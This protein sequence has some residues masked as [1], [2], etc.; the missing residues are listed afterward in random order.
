MPDLIFSKETDCRY[1]YKCLRNCPVKAVSFKSGKSTVVVEECIF[2]GTCLEVCPQSAR[3]YRK[4]TEK[5]LNLQRPFLVSIAPSFFAYFENP[6]KVI[7]SLKKMG[8][9]VVQ[10]TA[11]G[12]EIVSRRYTEV[13]EKND[14]PVVTTACP[15]V[16]NLAEKHFPH[17]LKYLTPIDSPLMAHAKFLKKRYGDFPVVFVGPCIAKKEESSLVDIALTFEELEEIIDDMK[18]EEVF[19]DP[20]YPNRARFFP[21]TDGINY[22][23]S[24]PWEKKMVV[25]GVENLMRVFSR[26]DEYRNVFIEA[27]ACYGSCLN[28]PVM[29]KKAAGKDRIPEWQKRLPKEP[30]VDSFEIETFRSFRNRSKSVDVSEEEV[31]K[32]LVSIGKDDPKKELN[33]GACGYDS[34][35]D[36]AKAVVLGK[37]EKEMCFVYLLDLVKSSSYR[38]VE[39]SPNAVFVLKE[40]KVIYRNKLAGDLSENDPEILT[41]AMKM[42]GN[43]LVLDERRYFFVKRFSLEEGEE[44]LMLVDVTQEK[45][46]EDE[47]N[48]LKQ[49]TLRKVE[50]ML[51]KQMRIAQEIAGILGE[52]IAETKSS[53]LELKMFMEGKNADL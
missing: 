6:L 45:L 5:L 50:E 10:E 32:V 2:C 21:T 17:V 15:V 13:F 34:C 16:V 36:K 19:P 39:E 30:K 47:L 53:F 23:V 28:G 9:M 22:T 29:R 27:S 31:R 46:K 43:T 52:S 42:V 8:A 38:V 4:D 14:G 18:A 49:E 11:V 41:K 12:A 24:I 35:R 1:C 25:E 7:G 33:C 48:R 40:G 37:A 26:I 51:N 44:V 3:S 20:P